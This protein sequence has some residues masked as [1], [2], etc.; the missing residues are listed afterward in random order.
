MRANNEGGTIKSQLKVSRGPGSRLGCLCFFFFSTPFSRAPGI[1]QIYSV[2]VETVAEEKSASPTCIESRQAGGHRTD[3][4]DAVR[5][6]KAAAIR[7]KY[8]LNICLNRNF[9]RRMQKAGLPIVAS[10]TYKLCS[11]DAYDSGYARYKNKKRSFKY[12]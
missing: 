3:G 5:P 1:L 2:F 7:I 6:E 10:E 11:T 9:G 4:P 12:K 8:F